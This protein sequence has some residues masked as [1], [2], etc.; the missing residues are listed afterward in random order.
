MRP[1]SLARGV[2][3]H[4][5]SDGG[6]EMRAAGD[7]SR[8]GRVT[9]ATI[10]LS[11]RLTVSCGLRWAFIARARKKGLTR[12]SKSPDARAA[13]SQSGGEPLKDKT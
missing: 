1:F 12:K 11:H 9:H 10:P 3:H 2:A 8:C 13:S 5:R 4:F 7:I 6:L